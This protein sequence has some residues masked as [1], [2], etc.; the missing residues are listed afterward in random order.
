MVRVF[1]E[2]LCIE[3]SDRVMVLRQRPDDRYK[4]QIYDVPTAKGDST[5]PPVAS[6]YNV[7][8]DISA[9]AAVK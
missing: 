4:L 6:D 8:R 1:I 7:G 3:P 5:G 2:H 9:V